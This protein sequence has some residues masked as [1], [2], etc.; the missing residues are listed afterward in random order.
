L[1]APPTPLLSYAFSTDPSPLQTSGPG[2]N[3]PGRINVS[4]SDPTVSTSAPTGTIYC[5]QIVIGVPIGS[6]AAALCETAPVQSASSGAWE[7]VEV[8]TGP[9]PGAGDDPYAHFT[10]TPRDNEPSSW[11][12]G[13]N[14]VLGLQMTVNQMPGSFDYKIAETSGTDPK[15]MVQRVATIPLIKTA[16][17]FYLQ[18]LVAV[19]PNQPASAPVI[20]LTELALGAPFA[21]QWESNGT[22]FEIYEKGSTAP[23]YSGSV[24]RYPADPNDP[25]PPSLK[26][27]TTFYL[28]ASVTGDPS[29]DSPSQGYETIYLYDSLTLTVSNPALTPSTVKATG[30]VATQADLSA[31]TL[32][33]SGSATVGSVGVDGAA[34][35][36]STLNVA[37]TV[38]GATPGSSVDMSG[39]TVSGVL[40]ATT[41]SVGDLKLATWTLWQDGNGNLMIASPGGGVLIASDLSVMYVNNRRLL[42]DG[43]PVNITND[44]GTLD[45]SANISGGGTG[46]QATAYWS[47]DC[48]PDCNLQIHYG[49]PW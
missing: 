17:Q 37:G 47:D 16:P 40:D 28:C 13:K 5:N 31:A 24:P 14:L 1:Q 36:G 29:G 41:I 26:T 19:T 42:C 46:W 8:R 3:T 48:D 34:T 32:G 12:V 23:V 2:G 20:P 11:N 22:W 15:E 6:G 35:V 45:G 10:F 25:S 39:A 7:T 38:S 18:N 27:D 43:D 4:A 21:L 33:V 49:N 44:R 30:D 9:W